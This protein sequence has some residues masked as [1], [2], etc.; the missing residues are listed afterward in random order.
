[1]VPKKVPD[2]NGGS[3]SRILPSLTEEKRILGPK[4]NIGCSEAVERIL[5]EPPF[6]PDTFN[7]PD[8]ANRAKGLWEIRLSI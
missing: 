2:T 4:S 1:M 7:S 6:V 8:A 5:N 3:L